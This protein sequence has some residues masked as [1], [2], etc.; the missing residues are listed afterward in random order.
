VTPRWWRIGV[1]YEEDGDP[2]TWTFHVRAVTERTARRL[3]AERLGRRR[4]AIYICRPSD[5][6][7]R[8]SPQEHVAADYGPYRRSWRDPSLLDL[9]ALLAT[10]PA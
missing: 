5:P 3:V 9:R 2:F 4:H 8:V 6:L 10:S 1:I 7:L